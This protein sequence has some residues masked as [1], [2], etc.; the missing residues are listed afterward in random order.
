MNRKYRKWIDATLPIRTGMISWPSDPIVEISGYKKINKGNNSNLSLLK[1][2]SHAGTHIDAPRHFFNDGATIDT[3]SPDVMVC[4][5]RVVEIADPFSVCAEELR[6]KNIRASQGILVRTKNSNA[7][8][9]EKRVSKKFVFLTLGA[10]EYLVSRRVKLVGIDSLSV[11]GYGRFDAM[12]VHKAL[13]AS[14]I[15][16]VEGLDLSRIRAGQ[17]DMLCLPLKVYRGDAAPA[18]VLLRLRE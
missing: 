3:I 12:P 7:R 11:G 14:G 18:R 15:W 1:L 16:I 4:S 17:Y 8:W 5:V 10:A 13:L 6:S 2:G 9:W